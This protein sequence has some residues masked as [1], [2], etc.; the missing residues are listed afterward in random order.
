[1]SSNLEKIQAAQAAAEAKKNSNQKF[2]KI[3]GV[4]HTF[5][6]GSNQI[7]MLGTYMKVQTHYIDATGKKE[8]ACKKSSFTQEAGD[9]RI[10]KVINCPDWDIETES[11]KSKEEL[12]CP[13][14]AIRRKIYEYMK[15]N[16]ITDENAKKKYMALINKVSVTEAYKTNIIDRNDPYVVEHTEGGEVKKI[17]AKIATITRGAW[18][19]LEPMFGKFKRDLADVE[20]G[21]DIDIVKGSN[22]IRTEYKVEPVLDDDLRPLVTPLNDEEK[23]LKLNDLK[24][25]CGKQTDVNK[26]LVNLQDDMADIY[27]N[28]FNDGASVESEQE[29]TQQEVDTTSDTTSDDNPDCFGVHDD[30]KDDCKE[31]PSKEA[32]IEASK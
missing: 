21:I 31:C 14:C 15:E 12:T 23:A 29:D 3:D 19:L 28:G 4:F 1:M 7:R 27:E 24:V 30:S 32:C 11:W 18:K 9:N 13:L 8:G 20:K 25:I 5:K 2:N 10:Q 6:D 26:V 16:N 22:G 17:G